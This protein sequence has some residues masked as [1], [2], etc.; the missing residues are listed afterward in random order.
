MGKQ[1]VV[2][3]AGRKDFQ[4]V[5]GGVSGGLQLGQSGAREI[6]VEEKFH[7]LNSSGFNAFHGGQ[8]TGKFQARADVRLLE[9]R[10]IPQNILKGLPGGHRADDIGDKNPR[11]AH[12]GFAVANGRI[13]TDAV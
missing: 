6:F 10:I 9:R 4:S 1:L 7:S 3:R 13:E 8:T 2:G 5:N 12:H 11:A